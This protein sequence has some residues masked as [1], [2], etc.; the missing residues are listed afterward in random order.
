MLVFNVSQL[1]NCII[2]CIN[3]YCNFNISIQNVNNKILMSLILIPL[4]IKTNPNGNDINYVKKRKQQIYIQ[5]KKIIQKMK[6]SQKQN[7]T[8]QR[9]RYNIAQQQQRMNS[10]TMQFSPADQTPLPATNPNHPLPPQTECPIISK[11][12]P[13]NL[14]HYL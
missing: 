1:P 6:I 9:Y 4:R 14:C 5:N 2:G 3:N 11:Q 12:I 7:S 10:Y 13:I 8:K